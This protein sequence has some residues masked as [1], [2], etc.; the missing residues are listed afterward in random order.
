MNRDVPDGADASIRLN[1]DAAPVVDVDKDSTLPA[2]M[3]G[4]V[5]A[6]AADPAAATDDLVTAALVDEHL[7]DLAPMYAEARR[8]V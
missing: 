3:L 2:V 8:L 7:A 1:P 6:S 5:T 4:A